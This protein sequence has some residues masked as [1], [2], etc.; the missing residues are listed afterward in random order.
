MAGGRQCAFSSKLVT[1][2]GDVHANALWEKHSLFATTIR[3]HNRNLLFLLDDTNS[4]MAERKCSFF[5]FVKLLFTFPVVPTLTQIVN[6]AA[7]E[8][9][10]RAKQKLFLI[11]KCCF[12][13]T[14]YI[15]LVIIFKLHRADKAISVA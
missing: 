14:F 11:V 5:T 13:T 6:D 4:L 10:L 7:G 2:H 9:V 1:A 3:A 15:L 8:Q 12:P